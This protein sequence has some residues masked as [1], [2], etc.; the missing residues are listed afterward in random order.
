M[1][2]V[3]PMLPGEL[4]VAQ[5]TP[6]GLQFCGKCDS[7]FDSFDS[8]QVYNMIFALV[9]HAKKDDSAMF[10][11]LE[12]ELQTSQTLWS[13]SFL[14]QT[15][16]W[17]GLSWAPKSRRC[18]NTKIYQKPILRQNMKVRRHERYESPVHHSFM[19]LWL[20][21]YTAI[22]YIWTTQFDMAFFMANPW[23]YRL[24]LLIIIYLAFLGDE[25]P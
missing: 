3:I 12:N 15:H 13:L 20:Y 4:C 9:R 21:G 11:Q 18:F 19:A 7:N 8:V 16:H 14:H 17:W 23:W 5:F 25:H 24:L 6:N 22:R 2:V 1:Q 10:N